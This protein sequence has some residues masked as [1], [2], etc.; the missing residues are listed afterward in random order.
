MYILILSCGNFSSPAKQPSLACRQL[1][2]ECSKRHHPQSPN[3][4]SSSASCNAKPHEISIRPIPYLE[5]MDPT[6]S[7]TLVPSDMCRSSPLS[8][9]DS[10]DLLECRMLRVETIAQVASRPSI[11]S[12]LSSPIPRF[13]HSR[14][15][16]AGYMSSTRWHWWRLVADSRKPAQEPLRL[17]DR[18]P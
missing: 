14:A 10:F 6:M 18:F 7:P 12:R 5:D 13:C 4:P 9:P 16:L 2:T 3:H 11:P 15:K 17:G 1:W 8:T